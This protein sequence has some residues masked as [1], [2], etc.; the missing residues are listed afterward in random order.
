M[1][2]LKQWREGSLEDFSR[3]SDQLQLGRV[4]GE[5]GCLKTFLELVTN[6]DQLVAK[7]KR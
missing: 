7:L 4:Q 6:S 2:Y 3:V 5:S 1:Q